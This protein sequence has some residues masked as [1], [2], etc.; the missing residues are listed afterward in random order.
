MLHNA[1]WLVAIGGGCGIHKE[2]LVGLLYSAGGQPPEGVSS[3]FMSL[4]EYSRPAPP[5]DGSPSSMPCAELVDYSLLALIPFTEPG[6]EV[7]DL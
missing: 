6:L 7:L 2:G 5:A 3:A 4:F 1:S